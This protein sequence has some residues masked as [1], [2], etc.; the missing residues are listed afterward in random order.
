MTHYRHGRAAGPATSM[1]M[2]DFV[3][4]CAQ[5]D[6]DGTEPTSY[7]IPHPV[8]AEYLRGLRKRAFLLGLPVSG[9]AIGNMRARVI[10]VS[11][12]AARPHMRRVARQDAV[13][14]SSYAFIWAISHTN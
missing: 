7:Y 11:P 12:I 5:L 3:D 8:S 10:A 13:S 14:R 1:T 2:E 9:T 4:L 6:L